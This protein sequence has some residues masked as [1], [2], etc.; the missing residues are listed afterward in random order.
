MNVR[1][2]FESYRHAEV[3]GDPMLVRHRPRIRHH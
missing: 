1:I 3:T 2:V